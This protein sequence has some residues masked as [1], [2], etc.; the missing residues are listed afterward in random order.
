MKNVY[1]MPV[2]TTSRK[3]VLPR[4]FQVHTEDE[5]AEEILSAEQSGDIEWDEFVAEQ[6]KWEKKHLK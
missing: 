3:S 5:L 1:K 4:L 6:S 2:A